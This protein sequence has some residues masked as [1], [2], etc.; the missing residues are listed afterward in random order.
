MALLGCAFQQYNNQTRAALVGAGMTS[1]WFCPIPLNK[2]SR[3]PLIEIMIKVN[4]NTI[5]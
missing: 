2:P 4:F 1:L 5:Q 3:F